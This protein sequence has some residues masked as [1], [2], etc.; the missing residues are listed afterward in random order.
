LPELKSEPDD[1]CPGRRG[2]YRGGPG[3]LCDPDPSGACGRSGGSPQKRLTGRWERWPEPA[4]GGN[5]S[6]KAA[7]DD[8]KTASIRTI[9]LRFQVLTARRKL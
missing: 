2:A 6:D 4:V 5:G 8:W 3:G 7:S 1:V 9:D